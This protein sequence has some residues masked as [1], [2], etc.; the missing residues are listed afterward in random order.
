MPVSAGAKDIFPEQVTVD[1]QQSFEGIVVDLQTRR[2]TSQEARCNEN[3]EH[4]LAELYSETRFS[5]EAA[6]I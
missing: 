4:E 3:A 2:K 1:F 5:K 6:L